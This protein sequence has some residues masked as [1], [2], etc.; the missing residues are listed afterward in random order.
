MT[1]TKSVLHNIFV[2][3]T[4]KYADFSGRADRLEQ[5][6]FGAFCFCGTVVSL[7][8]DFSF[9]DASADGFL[10]ANTIFIYA[11]LV[12]MFAVTARRLH[13]IGRSGWWQLLY[14]VP[15]PGLFVLWMWLP[16]RGMPGP[17]RYNTILPAPQIKRLTP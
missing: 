2:C 5:W 17:N 4:H 6:S 7:I 13:D 14:L 1:H 9:L 12:P 16:R 3:M 8:I 11:V 15:I 10:L